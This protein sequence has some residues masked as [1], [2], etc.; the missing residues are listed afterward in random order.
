MRRGLDTSLAEA[1]VAQ[2]RL[3]GARMVAAWLHGF[4]ERLDR[5]TLA[6]NA[7]RI[8]AAAAAVEGELD[9]AAELAAR[10]VAAHEVTPLRLE[11]ARS[12]L[13]LG[14]VERRRRAR[15]R[16]RDA[17]TRAQVLARGLGHRPLLALVEE[18][19]LRVGAAR[20]A[21]GLTATEQ[22]VAELVTG[23]AGNRDAAA[24]M[25]VSVRT[26]ETHIASVYRKLGVRDR[27]EL[28]RRFG[29]R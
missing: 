9:R 17:L 8:G 19:L 21:G 18:E 10:A 25:F 7:Y 1:Y 27:S 6:G 16:S 24:A 2:S 28:R 15:H 11:L 13:T 23:G 26:V 14:R 12:L 22:R 3:D 29:P 5:P 4:G 20:A